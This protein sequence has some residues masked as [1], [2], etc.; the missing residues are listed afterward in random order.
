MNTKA[1]QYPYYL[2]AVAIFLALASPQLLADGM[3]MD[4]LYYATVAHNLA[5][6]LGSFWELYL[7]ETF[8]NPFRE[9]P[10]LAMGLQSLFFKLAGSSLYVERLYS[11]A[12]FFLTGYFI[13]RLWKLMSPSPYQSLAWL[14]LLFWALT[15][16]VPWAATNNMLENTLMIFTTASALFFIK[17]QLRQKWTYHLLAGLCLA[18]AVLTKGLVGLFPLSMAFWFWVLKKEYRWPRFVKDTALLL[19]GTLLPFVLLFWLW[20]QSYQ[21]LAGYFQKQIVGSLTQ[22]QTVSSRFFIVGALFAQQ[23]IALGLCLVFWLFSRKLKGRLQFNPTWFWFLILLGLAGVLPIMVSLKQR[24]F[25]ILA[26]FPF[27][28]LALAYAFKEPVYALTLRLRSKPFI[29]SGMAMLFLVISLFLNLRQI[30]SVGRD[31][32][33]IHDV[34]LILQKLPPH[35]TV[36]IPPGLHGNWSLHGYFHRYGTLSLDPKNPHPFYLARK[37]STASVP[38]GYQK[39]P[40]GLQAYALYQQVPAGL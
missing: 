31:A 1:H 22:V 5:N 14:P 33:E 4:G 40:L 3:F 36:S 11:V 38:V 17:G 10:P 25:Y 16:L 39:V 15:P 24:A 30:N 9:H 19:A 13:T 7:T 8:H 28:S 2:I 32:Q 6:G 18:L 34:R 29:L 26:T 12:T 35:T 21:S 27:F 37:N 23:A 20:P